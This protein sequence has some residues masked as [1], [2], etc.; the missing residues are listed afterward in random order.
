MNRIVIDQCYIERLNIG[1]SHRKANPAAIL[2]YRISE[3]G[4][5]GELFVSWR[6][7][8][9]RLA[10]RSSVCDSFDRV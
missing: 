7:N 8:N 5:G 10:M 6:L 4:G 2:L 9:V 3:G 1:Q